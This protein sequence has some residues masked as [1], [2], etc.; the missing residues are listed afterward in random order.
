MAAASGLAPAASSRSRSS[1]GGRAGERA[2]PRNRERSGGSS[3]RPGYGG[4]GSPT[5]I[6]MKAGWAGM[7]PRADSSA[8]LSSGCA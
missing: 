4:T 7:M 3:G 2:K 8:A 6:A 5:A 1:V